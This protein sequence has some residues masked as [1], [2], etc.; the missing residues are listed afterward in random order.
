VKNDKIMDSYRKAIDD[1]SDGATIIVGGNYEKKIERR[2][3]T[4]A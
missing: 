2:T 4:H 3:V 1:I